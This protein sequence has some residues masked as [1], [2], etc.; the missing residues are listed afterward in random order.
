[1]SQQ[2]PALKDEYYRLRV[3][4]EAPDAVRRHD[5]QIMQRFPFIDNDAG[6]GLASLGGRP[7]EGVGVRVP[8]AWLVGLTPAEVSHAR[9]LARTFFDRDRYVTEEERERML[10]R[11]CQ[12]SGLV[13]ELQRHVILVTHETRAQLEGEGVVVTECEDCHGLGVTGPEAESL[14]SAVAAGES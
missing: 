14:L 5:G 9:W 13:G 6:F 4:G 11:S 1:M 2:P 7:E 12:G 3:L 10:C 8:E